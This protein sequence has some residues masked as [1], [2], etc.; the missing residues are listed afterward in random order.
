MGLALPL[1]SRQWESAIGLIQIILFLSWKKT[2]S[3]TEQ[4][5]QI[6]NHSVDRMNK[7]KLQQVCISH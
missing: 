1:L 6:N 7:V 4:S 2:P 3:S 5:H